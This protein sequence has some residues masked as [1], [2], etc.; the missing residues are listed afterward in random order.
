MNH[1]NTGSG[2]VANDCQMFLPN[3][4][5]NMTNFTGTGSSS[6]T[7]Q[8]VT[9]YKH[10][11]IVTGTHAP[12]LTINS[13]GKTYGGLIIPAGSAVV[14]E[15]GIAFTVTGDVDVTG[16]YTGGTGVPTFGSL[17]INSG[18]VYSA[19][20]GTT[21]LTNWDGE[22][23]LNMGG[24]F[25]HN[26]G[27]V[28]VTY[29]GGTELDLVG[30]SGNLYNLIISNGGNKYWEPTNSQIDGDLTVTAGEFKPDG[31]SYNLT[32]LGHIILDGG[33]MDGVPSGT[34]NLNT[35]TIKTGSE[36]KKGTAT[37]NLNSLRNIGGA[38]I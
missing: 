27:T 13:A 6:F 5:L 23:T 33:N 14:H 28:D 22:F 15:A 19:T 25:T 29:N 26:N 35:L 32:V 3:S 16:V 17:N 38:V 34:Y 8:N 20:S 31:N 37:V 11:D 36:F 18:G 1:T 12:E 7:G 9:V 30:T 2:Q 4:G 10:D 24:T 21:T